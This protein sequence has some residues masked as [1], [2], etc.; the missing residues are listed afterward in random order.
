ME[1][2]SA[3]VVPDGLRNSLRAKLRAASDALSR[4]NVSAACGQL[5]AFVNEAQSRG[6]DNG[7]IHDAT[8]IRSA[9]G[10]R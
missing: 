7:L 3:L 5:G 2:V 9:A 6:V 8:A 10:C 4:G 1:D